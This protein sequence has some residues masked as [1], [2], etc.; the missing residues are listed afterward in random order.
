MLKIKCGQV[1]SISKTMFLLSSKGFKFGLELAYDVLADLLLI[2]FS[3]ALSQQRIECV[4]MYPLFRLKENEEKA[5][6]LEEEKQHF[7]EQA[8]ELN[9]TIKVML[10]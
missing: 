8:Q 3:Y 7:D 6:T 5:H 2:D 1:Y 4:I 10:I 9:E